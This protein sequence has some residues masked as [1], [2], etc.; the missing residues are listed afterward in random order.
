M[1]SSESDLD[2]SLSDLA[3]CYVMNKAHQIKNR[4]AYIHHS[5]LY[6][7]HLSA[8]GDQLINGF[9]FELHKTHVLTNSPRYLNLDSGQ[10]SVEKGTETAV[11]EVAAT[12]T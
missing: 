5:T 9:Y 7:S 2:L 8:N 3:K 6:V 11:K 4:F 12:K 1:L 10:F